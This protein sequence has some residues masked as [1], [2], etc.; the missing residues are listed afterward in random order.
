MR[1]HHSLSSSNSVGNLNLLKYLIET[2]IKLPMHLNQHFYTEKL[3]L[4][5]EKLNDT[6]F[7]LEHIKEISYEL[8]LNTLSEK[9]LGN[10]KFLLNADQASLFFCVS[11]AQMLGI[12]QV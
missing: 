9:I 8:D 12:V 7:L 2:K 11:H 1:K 5:S 4:T 10:I 3:R 6:D